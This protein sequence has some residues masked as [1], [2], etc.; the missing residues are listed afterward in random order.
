MNGQATT[1]SGAERIASVI[2]GWRYFRL[3]GK[4]QLEATRQVW[5]ERALTAECLRRPDHPAE[6]GL[7]RHERAARHLRAGACTCGVYAL[8]QPRRKALDERDVVAEVLL[9]GCVVEH[10]DGYR[11]EHCRIERLFAPPFAI[12]ALARRYDV[13]VEP[14]R[15]FAAM[16]GPEVTPY[17][18]EGDWP[19]EWFTA[20]ARR[21][22]PTQR[23]A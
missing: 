10:E 21:S 15:T 7:A 3:A 14:H 8:K 2:R 19:S 16:T 4:A 13:A 20:S 18:T 11:A 12:E 1:S 9:W 22:S 17:W 23:T 6:F 5:P